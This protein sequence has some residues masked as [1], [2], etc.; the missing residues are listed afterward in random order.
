MLV[1]RALVAL[2]V[3]VVQGTALGAAD[4]IPDSH[5]DWAVVN[6]RLSVVGSAAVG[7]VE[8]A[9]RRAVSRIVTRASVAPS[10]TSSVVATTSPRRGWIARHPVLFGTLAGAT[11]GTA[12]A[13]AAWGNE[14]AFVGLYG[15]AA[16]GAVVGAVLR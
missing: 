5:D 14:G 4:D 3:V 9:A 2:V 11:V 16:M 15:G 7:P 6:T 1:L 13:A 8:A 12:V 10:D